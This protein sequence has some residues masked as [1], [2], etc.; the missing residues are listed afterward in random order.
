[1]SKVI[2]MAALMTDIDRPSRGG[3]PR[4][5]SR[6]GVIRA[7]ILRLLADVGYGALTMDAVASEAGVGKA[8]IYRRWRTKQDLV[9]DTISDLN[10]DEATPPDTGS[11]REDLRLMMRQMVAMIT[12][13]TGAATLSLLSTMPHQP[14]LAEAFRNGPLAVWRQAFLQ[15][16]ERAEQRGEVGPGLAGS[17]A[18]ESTSA[19]LVQR[20][21]LTGGPVD[22]AYADAVLEAVVLPAIRAAGPSQV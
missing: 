21:L 1:M 12:G 13:P 22:D 6:D 19:L 5:P 11:L 8:T 17:M 14:A 15:I 3:R 18:A 9:V 20:W 4:D 2:I 16:W 7:A 10:R